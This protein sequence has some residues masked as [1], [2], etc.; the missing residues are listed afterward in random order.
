MSRI[1]LTNRCVVY[2]SDT[3]CPVV[4]FCMGSDIT[5]CAY[6]IKHKSRWTHNYKDT[7]MYWWRLCI[8]SGPRSYVWYQCPTSDSQ[9]YGPIHTDIQVT[10]TIYT[11]LHVT[12]S[13]TVYYTQTFKWHPPTRSHTHRPTCESVLQFQWLTARLATITAYYTVPTCTLAEWVR[14]GKWGEGGGGRLM[15]WEVVFPS[16]SPQCT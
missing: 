7:L 11:N 9:W 1:R 10:V 2:I 12:V 3:R 8:V 15:T 4:V 13:L 14:Q 6:R 5:A 16:W